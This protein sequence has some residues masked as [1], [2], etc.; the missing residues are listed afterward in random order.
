MFFCIGNG[1]IEINRLFVE[2]GNPM[3]VKLFIVTSSIVL[4]QV[5]CGIQNT[6]ELPD[7]VAFQNEFTKSF[8]E[9]SEEV[10][11]GHYLFKSETEGFT[12]HFPINASWTKL[13]MRELE[14]NLKQSVL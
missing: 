6:E 9:S 2:G 10:N 12:V 4:F 3:N 5:G 13:Y 7:T 11:K 14:M 8:L 1:S